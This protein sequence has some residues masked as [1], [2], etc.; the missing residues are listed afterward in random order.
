MIDV[1]TQKNKIVMVQ[2]EIEQAK[3]KKQRR[4]LFKY[5]M[6]LKKELRECY[7]HMDGTYGK[8]VV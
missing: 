4:D 8:K 2:W 5:L 7:M 3:S 6:R 1:E